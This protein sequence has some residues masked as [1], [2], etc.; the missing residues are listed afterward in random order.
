MHT[1]EGWR[2]LLL[3]AMLVAGFLAHVGGPLIHVPRVTLLLVIGAVAGPGVLGVVPAEAA[4]WFPF[5]SHLALA[6]IGFL[7][8]EEFRWRDV[9][10]K[11]PRVLAVSVG[12][13]LMAAVVVFVAV[14]LV[15]GDVVLALL[16]AGI[17]PASAPAAVVET[18][19]EGRAEGD[20]TDTVL[21]VVAIDDA[22]GVVTFSVLLVCASSVAGQ[23]AATE[24]LLTGLWEVGG[25]V[26]LGLA[27]GLPMAWISSRIRDGQITL[28]EATGIVFLQTGLAIMIGVSY[29]LA[30]IVLG[31]VVVNLAKRKQAFKEIEHVREPLLAVFFIVAG[32]K[33]KPDQLLTI[34]VLGAAYV[35]ARIAGLV[36]GGWAS[37]RMVAAPPEVSRRIGWCIT[38]QAGVALGFAL[39]AQD[40]LPRYGDTILTL[41]IATTILFEITGPLLTRIQLKRA[42]EWGAGRSESTS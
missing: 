26:L 4:D 3:G 13:V 32:L 20:L 24:Q 33:L 18:I 28:L 6:I 12:E 36:I 30:A 41:V 29:L 35:A 2:L 5:I 14:W 7:L 31:A 38:P 11:G 10:R 1:A 42:G 37:G 34:G 17:A 23:G 27:V 9:R 22:W 21:G 25:G 16:L 39:L 40:N 8:G 19:R 15:S